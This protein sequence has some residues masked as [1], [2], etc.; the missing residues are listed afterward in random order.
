MAALADSDEQI[1][2]SPAALSLGIWGRM[3]RRRSS[4]YRRGRV[5]KRACVQ[6]DFKQGG[7]DV[8]QSPRGDCGWRLGMTWL[9]GPICQQGKERGNVPLR[10]RGK[11]GHGPKLGPGQNGSQRP[12][13]IFSFV[14]PFPFLFSVSFLSFHNFWFWYSNE[15]KPICK[16]FKNSTQH[17]KIVRKTLF[18]N[19]LYFHENFMNWSMGLYFHNAK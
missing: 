17:F 4:I 14:S 19:K 1:R 11:L 16:F 9:V 13:F 3:E 8:A 6:W 15:I 12:F 10:G 5:M 7:N 2:N 18:K